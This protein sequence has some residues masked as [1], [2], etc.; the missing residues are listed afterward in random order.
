MSC[1]GDSLV[2]VA[3]ARVAS[4][5]H[6]DTLLTEAEVRAVE[7]GWRLIDAAMEGD[8]ETLAAMVRE[9]HR[10]EEGYALFQSGLRED[11]TETSRPREAAQVG[12]LLPVVR[13]KL[14]GDGR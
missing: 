10:L 8:A 2:S 5:P 11:Y 13:A 7:V 1:D 9:M 4:T 6:K 12:I 14:E 3:W